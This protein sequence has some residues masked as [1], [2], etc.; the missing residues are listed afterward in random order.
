L[1]YVGV[2]GGAVEALVVVLDQDLPVRLHLHDRLPGGAELVHAPLLVAERLVG[3]PGER[4]AQR[5]GRRLGQV[6][7][8]V[9]LPHL[10]VRPPQAEL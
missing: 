10:E 3:L 6:D 7:E 9:A 2:D 4:L 8:H 1:P 5:L